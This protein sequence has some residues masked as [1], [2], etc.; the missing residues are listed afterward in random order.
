M[1]AMEVALLVLGAV[2]FAASFVIPD[3]RAEAKDAAISK[4][5]MKKML[6]EELKNAQK[7]MKDTVRETVSSAVE[8]SDRSLEKVSNEKIMALNEYSESVLEEIGKT[9]KEAIFLYE[10][11][12][13]KEADLKNIVCK[14]EQM[15]LDVEELRRVLART[16]SAFPSSD[17]G[18]EAL[19]TLTGSVSNGTA[20]SDDVS[21]GQS[22][23]SGR[24]RNMRI[25]DL[26][27]Q[28][29][30]EVAIAREL[31]LGVGEVKLVIG[32]FEGVNE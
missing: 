26:H 23:T 13:D 14:A 28:G 25:L 5:E 22:D 15:K 20:D 7:R 6:D 10:M 17:C 4:D 21:E 3:M 9:H 2:L 11:L 30:T 24:N 19:L 29:E 31:G 1:T 8:Q 27:R 16:E 32:L 12:N 18:E